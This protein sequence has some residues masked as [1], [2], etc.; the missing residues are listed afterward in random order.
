MEDVGACLSLLKVGAY[1]ELVDGAATALAR[2]C[3]PFGSASLRP[4]AECC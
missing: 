1:H 3:A 2:Y 4:N